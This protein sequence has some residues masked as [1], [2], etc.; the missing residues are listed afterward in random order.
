VVDEAMIEKVETYIDYCRGLKGDSFVEAKVTLGKGVPDVYGTADFVACSEHHLTV[1]DLKTGQG[2][3]VEAK[4]NWQLVIYGIGA[5][6]MFDPL[7]DFE[8][9]TLVISQPPLNHHSEWELTKA[10]LVEWARKL[11]AGVRRTKEEPDLLAP[12]EDACR[13]CRARSFC[14]ALK[15]KVEEARQLDYK[16]MQMAD[17]A[18]AMELIPMVKAWLK[19]IEDH[20][21]ELMLNG[22]AVPGYKVVAGRGTRAWGD[23]DAAMKYI[24]GRVIGFE[25]TFCTLK[26]PSPAQAEKALKGATLRGKTKVVDL[27][28]LIVKHEGKPTVTTEDDKRIALVLGDRAAVDFEE[29]KEDV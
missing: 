27:S 18:Q 16:D 5:F 20:S 3:R 10:E 4:N 29:F 17:L 12:S 7:Y 23:Q 11:V 9:I 14:P 2:L 1:V 22:A 13:W 8:T 19:G 28:K 26:Y 21:K 24:K 15:A 25:D 6:R